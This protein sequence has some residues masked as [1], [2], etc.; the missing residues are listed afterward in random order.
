[1]GNTSAAVPITYRIS[2]GRA[3]SVPF[4]AGL[5]NEE[6]V[7]C[8]LSGLPRWDS[9][10]LYIYLIIFDIFILINVNGTHKGTQV[11]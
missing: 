10:F 4:H 2:R 11:V 8:F 7:F 6:P 1:M 5:W 9:N 3:E